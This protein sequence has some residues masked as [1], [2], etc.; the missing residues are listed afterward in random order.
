MSEELGLKAITVTVDDFQQSNWREAIK[1]TGQRGYIDYH[2]AFSKAARNAMENRDMSKSKVLWLLSAVCSMMFNPESINEP[3]K[4]LSV[5]ADGSRSI[6]PDDFTVHDLSFFEGI[7]PAIDD[8]RLKARIAD[9]LWLLIMPR[10]V[11]YAI[12]AIDSYRDFPLDINSLKWDGKNAWRRAIKLSQILN[13]GAVDRLINIQESLLACF[14]VAEISDG[15]HALWLSRVLE[16]TMLDKDKA[17]K[18]AGKLE[19]FA[20]LCVK[21]NAWDCAREYYEAAIRWFKRIEAHSDMYRLYATQAET[22]VSEADER[23]T[24]NN[25]SNMAAGYFLEKAIH[26]YRKIPKKNRDLFKADDRINELHKMMNNANKLSMT[27]MSGIEMPGIDIGDEVEKVRQYMIGYK[28]PD[29][30]LRFA[31]IYSGINVDTISDTGKKVMSESVLRHLMPATFMTDDGRVVAK[32]VGGSTNADT[33]QA[34][35]IEMIRCHGLVASFVVQA[36]IVP[37]LLVINEE[38]RITEEMMLSLCRNSNMIP[39]GREELWAKGLFA[40]FDRDF[41]V[42]THLLVPQVEHL[43]R[44]VMKNND[45]KTTTL[46]SAGIET[47]NGLSAL[48]D[49]PD[50]EKAVA[51]N[52]VFEFKALLADPIGPNLRNQLAHGL[53]EADGAMSAYAIYL[54]WLCCRLIINSI[55]WRPREVT[56]EGK[57]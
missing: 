53:L 16:L 32:S 4:P 14:N 35:W 20:N 22:F 31:S 7:L 24:G 6:L 41:I 37:A 46:D 47:E 44:A 26:T 13:T 8:Y 2:R 43:V 12:C 11:E 29:V 17:D 38:H 23:T 10:K 30:L 42:S 27:E 49:N 9:I 36:G 40:G 1:D 54:W 39:T 18:V 3:F 45:L 15:A 33:A 51:K 50:I 21:D 56:G 57:D 55:A 25:P 28:Y 48:L 52:I 34:H 5:W 19:A